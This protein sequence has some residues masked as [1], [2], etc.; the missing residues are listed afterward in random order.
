M[1]DQLEVE[2]EEVKPDST[3][4]CDE[5]DRMELIM[6]VEEEFDIEIS[7]EMADKIITVEDLHNAVASLLDE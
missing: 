7:D 1:I 4:F 6:T 5:L 2:E 3:I